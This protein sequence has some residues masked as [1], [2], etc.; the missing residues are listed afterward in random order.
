MVDLALCCAT[1]GPTMR[2]GLIETM[3]SLRSM[4]NA[5]AAFSDNILAN[6]CH[7]CIHIYNLYA[8]EFEFVRIP[9]LLKE[10]YN[11]LRILLGYHKAF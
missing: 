11:L 10:K 4:A 3:L 8:R 7:N 2:P 1:N 5:Q 9:L 6:A